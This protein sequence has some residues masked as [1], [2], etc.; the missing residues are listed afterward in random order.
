MTF[1]E[2]Y[3]KDRRWSGKVTIMEI[4]HLTMSRKEKWTIAKTARYFGVSSGLVS[5][6][7][8]LA[9]AFHKAPE[10]MTMPTRQEALK[11]L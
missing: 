9:E 7:L 3:S 8:K 6:N 1:Y 2:Q 10:L 11:Q 5:E 4:Y